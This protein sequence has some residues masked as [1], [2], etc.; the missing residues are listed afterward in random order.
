[1]G[2][3]ANRPTPVGRAG[4]SLADRGRGAT[5]P[6]APGSPGASAA[7]WFYCGHLVIFRVQRESPAWCPVTSCSGG[8]EAPAGQGGQRDQLQVQIPA[9]Q[10]SDLGEESASGPGGGPGM[11]EPPQALAVPRSGSCR[12]GKG[13]PWER[14][15]LGNRW[16]QAGI[17][18]G[19]GQQRAEEAGWGGRAEP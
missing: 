17:Q 10:L 15:N 2:G 12:W 4:A 11:G 8:E 14:G 13:Q 7:L 18:G 19:L 1:M 3:N 6:P 9:L 5:Q 16:E